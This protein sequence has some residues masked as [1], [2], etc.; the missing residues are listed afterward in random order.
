MSLLGHFGD[1]NNTQNTVLCLFEPGA[2]G[3]SADSFPTEESIFFGTRPGRRRVFLPD[4]ATVPVDQ[5]RAMITDWRRDETGEEH[6]DPKLINRMVWEYRNVTDGYGLAAVMNALAEKHPGHPGAD[7]SERE[8]PLMPDLMQAVNMASADSRG[9]LA[10][11]VP[12]DGDRQLEQQLAQLAFTEGIAGRT[13]VVRLTVTE[14]N[15]LRSSGAVTGGTDGVGFRVISP[16]P[17]GLEADVYAELSPATDLKSLGAHLVAELD[18][19]REVWRKSD[20]T[21]HMRLA[22]EQGLTWSEYDPDVDAIV[23]IT[24]DT[25]AKKLGPERVVH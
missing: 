13:H 16:D 11:V 20:R 22:S 25:G 12:E 9:V 8:L 18:A 7:E 10:L 4:M 24:P 19:F 17:F 15:D 2:E 14:W 3:L 21:T 1:A 23:A 5:A 6:P